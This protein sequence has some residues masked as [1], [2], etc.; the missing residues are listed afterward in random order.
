M[1]ELFL[2]P[3]EQLIVLIRNLY[4]GQEAIV[5]TEHIET[6]WSHVSK[7]MKQGHMVKMY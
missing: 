3:Y 4:T 2:R 1:K 6:V 7:G 5:H